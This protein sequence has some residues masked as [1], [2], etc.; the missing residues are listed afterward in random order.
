MRSLEI[1]ES[2]IREFSINSQEVAFHELGAY[3]KNHQSS[4]YSLSWRRFEELA[5]DVFKRNGYTTILTAPRKDDGA[6]LILLENDSDKQLAIVEC[7]KYRRDRRIGVHI[8]RALVGASIQWDTKHAVLLTT[9]DFT[10]GARAAAA[11]YQSR[12]F[13]I[14]L[15][16]ASELLRMLGAYDTRLPLLHRLSAKQRRDIIE[17]NAEDV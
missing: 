6:D 13:R 17:G 8:I 10:K 2:V 9:S 7:K 15:A 14:D 1:E 5:E 3:L 4:L 16:D 11:M 12:G